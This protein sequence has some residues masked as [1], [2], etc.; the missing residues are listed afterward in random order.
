MRGSVV[1]EFGL[2]LQLTFISFCQCDHRNKRSEDVH[3][4]STLATIVKS[5]D[6]IT[7]DDGDAL[8]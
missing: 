4:S 2:D 6:R 7:S 5:Y 8:P 3:G 1:E